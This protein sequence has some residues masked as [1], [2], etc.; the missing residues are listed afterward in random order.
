VNVIIN[1][2]LAEAV[3]T[4]AARAVAELEIWI[5]GVSSSADG[6]FVTVWFICLFTLSSVDGGLKLRCSGMGFPGI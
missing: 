4:G 1:V 5:I 2:I 6:A 3:V